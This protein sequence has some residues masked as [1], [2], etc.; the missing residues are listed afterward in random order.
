MRLATVLAI[1]ALLGA[2]GSTPNGASALA[3]MKA[4]DE[5][6]IQPPGAVVV[7]EVAREEVKSIFGSSLGSAGHRFRTSGT[8]GEVRDFF[9][10]EL[11]SRGWTLYRDYATTPTW[12]KGDLSFELNFD[13]GQSPSSGAA[14]SLLFDGFIFK[15]AP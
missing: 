3:S 10:R 8:A 6:D 4:M 7:G 15:A 14:E 9:N 5:Y 11:S 2:C 13:V 1:C 12:Q